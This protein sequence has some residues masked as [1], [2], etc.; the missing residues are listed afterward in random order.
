MLDMRAFCPFLFVDMDHRMYKT[1]IVLI[2]IVA[3]GVAF[4]GCN[5]SVQGPKTVPVTGLIT[6]KGKPVEGALVLFYPSERGAGIKT[7]SGESDST[8]NFSLE[9]HVK[10]STYKSGGQP[11]NYLVTVEK[12][13]SSLSANPNV[14][15]K[16]LLPER[17]RDSSTS[18]FSAEVREGAEN[19]FEFNLE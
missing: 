3:T 7:G 10:G 6:L 12:I 15:P 19:R 14:P 18:G 8:G 11:A 13:D 17:Y 5:P 4:P 16:N 1:R 2:A 9:S